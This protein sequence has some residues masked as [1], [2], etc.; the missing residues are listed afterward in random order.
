MLHPLR[1]RLLIIYAPSVHQA[2][3]TLL[4]DFLLRRNQFQLLREH[5]AMLIPMSL[6][7]EPCSSPVLRGGKWLRHVLWYRAQSILGPARDPTLLPARTM[8]SAVSIV[9]HMKIL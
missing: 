9:N 1:F 5:S 6:E 4:L 7:P 2:G 8:M 3:S